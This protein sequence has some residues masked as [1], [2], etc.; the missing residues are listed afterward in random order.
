MNKI[1]HMELSKEKLAAVLAFITELETLAPP[2]RDWVLERRQAPKPDWKT[3]D[4]PAIDR[5]YRTFWL[6][7]TG[8]ARRAYTQRFGDSYLQE[9]ARDLS[10]ILDYCRHVLADQRQHGTWPRPDACRLLTSH[11]VQANRFDL[12]R[13]VELGFHRQAVRSDIRKERALP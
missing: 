3:L 6:A 5:L 8:T 7:Q 2:D 1:R 12:A 11:L 4:L 13:R 10:M 9:V